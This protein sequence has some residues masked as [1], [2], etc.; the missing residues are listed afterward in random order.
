MEGE[1]PNK[2]YEIRVTYEMHDSI[3]K[4]EERERENLERS[5]GEFQAKCVTS[6][7]P[8]CCLIELVCCIIQIICELGVCVKKETFWQTFGRPS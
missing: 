2:K 5:I 4:F 1:R 6:N 3:L 8:Y 7:K